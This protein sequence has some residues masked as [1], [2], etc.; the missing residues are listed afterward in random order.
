MGKID[1]K[2]VSLMRQ[3]YNRLNE[4][5][6]RQYAGLESIRFGWGGISKVHSILG[7]NRSS[8]AL[9]RKE[10]LNVEVFEEIEL[11]KQRRKGGGRKKN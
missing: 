10:I 1:A 9:G 8:I 2:I 11:S 3:H 4:K 7:L 5:D 6:R